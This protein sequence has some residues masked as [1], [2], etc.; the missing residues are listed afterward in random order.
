VLKTVVFKNMKILGERTAPPV[1]SRTMGGT[2]RRKERL[3]RLR[4]RREE[5]AERGR[6]T[7]YFRKRE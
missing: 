3:A 6:K 5:G 4:R 7:A 2:R 1:R